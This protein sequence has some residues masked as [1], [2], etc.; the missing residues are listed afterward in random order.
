MGALRSSLS[1]PDPN[2]IRPSEADIE[3]ARESSRRLGP[4]LARGTARAKGSQPA[5][6][7]RFVM[8]VGGES[9]EM[10]IPLSALML[11]Q[12]ILTEM[13]AG[14]A[15]AL[16]PVHAELSTQEAADLLGVS[17]P[18]LTGLLERG[19]IPCR[20]IGTHRRVVF[21]DLQNYKKGIDDKRRA[22]LDE[23]AT[24][25]QELDMGY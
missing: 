10:V 11:L 18:F 6:P 2:L 22:A 1:R 17:R 9:K 24:Q 25:A 20:K 21:E 12:R 8:E 3:Q 19:E 13:A 14:N 4:A 15:M 23:L 7:I 5:P 16:Y